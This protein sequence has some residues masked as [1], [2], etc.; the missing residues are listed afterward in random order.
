[1]FASLIINAFVLINNNSNIALFLLSQGKKKQKT[2]NY[3]M[4][5]NQMPLLKTQI[6]GPW[7]DVL[8][9]F[10]KGNTKSRYKS[11]LAP[12]CDQVS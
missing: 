8:Y 7:G 12:T 1:M 11:P 4:N 6:M 3:L 10:L 5:I 2:G 9:Y